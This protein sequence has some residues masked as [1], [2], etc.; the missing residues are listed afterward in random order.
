VLTA[1]GTG[2]F[3]FAHGCAA[4]ISQNARFGNPHFPQTGAKF[5]VLPRPTVVLMVQNL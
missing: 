3:E 5:S 2:K 1:H 4:N